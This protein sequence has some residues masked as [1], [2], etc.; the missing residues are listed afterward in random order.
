[1]TPGHVLVTVRNHRVKLNDVPS[2]EARE[3][4]FWL[5]LISKAVINSVGAADWNVVQNNG[6][7]H[8]LIQ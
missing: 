7:W 6:K 3:L 8:S 2:D 4:G 5:P 1:M